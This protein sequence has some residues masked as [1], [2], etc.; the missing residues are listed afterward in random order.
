MTLKQ[1]VKTIDIDYFTESVSQ[2][3]EVAH[4]FG[5]ELLVR[6]QSLVRA[7]LRV[8]SALDLVHLLFGRRQLLSGCCSEGLISFLAVG[9][10]PLSSLSCWPVYR[11]AHSIEAGFP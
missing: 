1:Q 5:V 11:A 8:Q 6:L 10:R 3:V 4:V 9:H 2:D 7:Q